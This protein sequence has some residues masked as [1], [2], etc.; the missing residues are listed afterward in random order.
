MPLN[1]GAGWHRARVPLSLSFSLLFG[2]LVNVAASA[3]TIGYTENSAAALYRAASDGSAAALTMLKQAAQAGRP[4]AQT[5]LGVYYGTK[6]QYRR[7]DFWTHKA[8]LAGNAL[9]EFAYGG[10]YFYSNGVTRDLSMAAY[11]YRLSAM[12]GFMP[13]KEM[14]A[15]IHE[16]TPA[17][18]TA[19]G[20]SSAPIANVPTA[21]AASSH[22]SHSSMVPSPVSTAAAAPAD[23]AAATMTAAEENRL[24]YSYFYGKGKTE[25]PALAVQ[26]FEKAAAK[27][28]PAAEDNLGVAY[29]QGRGVPKSHQKAI[30][31]Y[32]KAAFAGYAE[33]QVNLGV[34][35][36][37]GHD[38][39]PGDLALA[40]YWWQKAVDQGSST[41]RQYLA[42][43]GDG[44]SSP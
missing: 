24:G 23:V 5:W 21:I 34:A 10:A 20:K 12:Q 4:V 17:S 14:L 6:S 15:R 32:R 33:A 40:R 41:A 42:A 27:G 19:G 25:N 29:Y 18:K 43:T 3:E 36:Y 35:Y 7:A 44:K 39:F 2:S 38:G 1:G 26:W 9:A 8:A 28:Y 22:A 31:W 13:A 37:Q 11:W 30:Y 16:E